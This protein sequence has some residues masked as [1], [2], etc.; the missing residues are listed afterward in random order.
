[1]EKEPD[2]FAQERRCLATLRSFHV[3][4]MPCNVM[5]TSLVP[6][7][8]LLF[9]LTHLSPG[10]AFVPATP[11]PFPC[12]LSSTPHPLTIPTPRPAT[13]T[14]VSAF[15]NDDSRFGPSS[16]T[17]SPGP[18]PPQGR[19]TLVGAGPGDP[20]L[21]TLAAIR[22]MATADLVVADRLIPPEMLKLVTGNL[23]IAGKRPGCADAAQKEIY[24]WVRDGM[25]ARQHVVR[26]KIGDPFLFG[27]GGEEVLEFR[28]KLG[29]D[30]EIIPGVS[31]A[32]AAPLLAAIPVTHRGVSNQVYVCTGFGKGGDRPYLAPFY[33]NQTAVFLMAVGRL[34]ELTRQLTSVAG[35]PEETPVAIVE[36]A[37]TPR[38]R[39]VVATL[40]KIAAVAERVRVTAPA[41]V[42]VGEVVRVL[43]EE[44]EDG[45][46][47]GRVIE[48]K[49]GGKGCGDAML[50]YIGGAMTDQEA[51]LFGA[52]GR[53]GGKEEGGIPSFFK[54]LRRARD[55]T[56]GRSEEVEEG[57]KEAIMARRGGGRRRT[58]RLRKWKF[59]YGRTNV[60]DSM[61]S[62]NRPGP[63]PPPSPPVRASSS[64]LASE[65]HPA[66]NRLRIPFHSSNDGQSFI[67]LDDAASVAEAGG[68]E[69]SWSIFDHPVSSISSV[70]ATGT[71]PA[72]HEILGRRVNFDALS[73]DA[74]LYSMLRAWVQDDP[75]R[76]V[77][78][79]AMSLDRPGN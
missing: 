7:F 79:V 61:L 36:Q 6:L 59:W 31:S 14:A 35:Y 62:R 21:L 5:T 1:M 60:T 22:A 28:E 11:S 12:I 8:P 37:S 33:V 58:S 65:P 15:L 78:W 4:Q 73:A 29:V 72:I 67:R 41:V 71:P 55:E 69:E 53:G 44:G 51:A 49:A 16:L 24:Q 26:L 43:L 48:G 77:P 54:R 25:A 10:V 76:Q 70:S 74:S 38:Q 39:T 64:P 17:P 57:A 50:A 18:S 52:D 75:T 47:G 32:F 68:E 42:V 13:S 66:P 63:A 20:D 9:A 34:R 30:P 46:E 2:G 45:E 23:K 19:I 40:D 27:R 3:I 56:A